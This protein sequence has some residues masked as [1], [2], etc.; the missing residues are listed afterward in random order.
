MQKTNKK[1]F[2][3]VELIVVI[4]ILAIL[5]TIW[6]LSVQWYNENARNSVKVTDLA[7]IDTL[8]NVNSERWKLFNVSWLTKIT[9]VA[10]P[11][12]I[13]VYIWYLTWTTIPWLP[14]IPLDPFTE[15]PYLVWLY[16]K[17]GSTNS[18]YAQVW[19]VLENKYWD[20]PL[21]FLP[22]TY[23]DVKYW[24]AWVPIQK[25]VWNYQSNKILWI[26]WLIPRWVLEDYESFKLTNYFTSWEKI[27]WAPRSWYNN[28]IFWMDWAPV[29][30]VEWYTN[31]WILLYESFENIKID[32]WIKI[33]N[34]YN[35]NVVIPV[36][37]SNNVSISL[38]Y[39][40]NTM[41]YDFIKT[42][43]C[44]VDNI[45]N[46]SKSSL[47]LKWLRDS[48]AWDWQYVY[49]ILNPLK[50]YKYSFDVKWHLNP[51]VDWWKLRVY[52]WCY[53]K[54]SLWVNTTLWSKSYLMTLD[55][56][57]FTNISAYVN[58]IDPFWNWLSI[59]IPSWI[60]DSVSCIFFRTNAPKSWDELWFD[61]YI[62]EEIN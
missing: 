5:W 37:S 11:K 29:Y 7:N 53:S 8:I 33:W 20:V 44:Q 13:D 22:N 27:Y 25:I 50:K 52:F 23:A 16:V 41:Y 9:Y 39:E 49:M 12:D 17:P 47:Y 58:E 4:T 21:G 24:E 2:T 51:L 1:A 36:C 14:N 15:K 19:T 54:N 46:N 6:F 3:L 40:K 42:T 28:Y 56:N 26:S 34:I 35:P 30:Q 55:N 59:N 62:I 38:A 48:I 43:E 31:T 57:N 60:T 61:N 10:Y 18:M 45:W 32:N